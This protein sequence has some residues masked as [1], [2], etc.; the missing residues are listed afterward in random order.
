MKERRLYQAVKIWWMNASVI[1]MLH[2]NL[3]TSISEIS[4][5]S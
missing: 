1:V 5:L 4:N 3:K 2:Q